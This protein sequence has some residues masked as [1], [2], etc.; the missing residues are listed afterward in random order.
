MRKFDLFISGDMATPSGEP[1]GDL[2]FDVI[3]SAPYLSW[4]FLADQL[5]TGRNQ[6]YAQEH[7]QRV[8][9]S[10]SSPLICA[11][12]ICS[13]YT[14]WT[15]PQVP[16]LP[17]HRADRTPNPSSSTPPSSP[18][19]YLS[20]HDNRRQTHP[21]S[22]RSGLPSPAAGSVHRARHRMTHLES[23]TSIGHNVTL[24]IAQNEWGAFSISTGAR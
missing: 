10:I 19:S 6:P 4:A 11:W 5:P 2:A 20:A 7:A 9:I 12:A 16:H 14:G 18:R 3:S 8:G 23:N 24:G 15:A 21:E 13:P 1:V 17:S 22:L